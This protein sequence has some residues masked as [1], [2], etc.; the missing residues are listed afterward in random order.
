MNILSKIQSPA[1]L[2]KLERAD[3]QNL[4]TDI[5]KYLVEIIPS[6]GGHFA[7]SL[8][9]VELSVALHFCFD[10]PKDLLIW[11]V[12]HQSYVHKILTGRKEALKKIRQF[13]GISGFTKRSESA[14]D[15]FGAGHASTSISAALGLCTARD[16][17]AETH[18]V[19]AIIGDGSLTGGLA[20]EGLNN[21]GQ[22]GK[23]LLVILNDNNMSISPN[24]GAIAYYLNEIITNPLYQRINNEVWDLTGK[25]PPI[26]E[27]LRTIARKTESSLKAMILPGMLFE[28]LGF[29]YF[30]PVNGHDLNELISYL[31]RLKDL[32]GPVLL[33]VLTKKG[34][35]FS[36]AEKHPEKYH[37]I[38]PST[39]PNVTAQE[40]P[41]QLSYTDIFGKVLVQLAELDP[42]IC[43]ITAA[44]CDG[45]GLNDFK[46]R[47]PER[48][49]DVGIAEEH[50]VTYAAG[51]AAGGFRPVVSIYS[52]FLQRAF[53][54][55]IHDVALQ[56]LPVVLAID[57]GG[58]VGED[59]PTHHGSFDLSYL[60]LIPDLIIASPKDGQELRNLLY[61]ATRQNESPFV[62]RYPRDLAPD[63][64]NLNADFQK[65]KI[66]SWD[67]LHSGENILL[68]AV[69]SMVQ[70]CI[71]TLPLL[72]KHKINPTLVNCRFIKPIDETLLHDLL[73]KHRV[74]LTLE[75]NSLQGGFGQKI[76]NIVISGEYARKI[77][78]QQ[79][80]LPDQ[81]IT[82]GERGILLDRI[83]LSAGQIAKW[84]VSA[85]KGKKENSKSLPEHSLIGSLITSL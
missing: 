76:G 44:M 11:D 53:D 13:G 7:S 83:G 15:A 29:R 56:K 66:G 65:I 80:G 50:A 5:R 58:L 18:R 28:D 37:G 62:I 21:A 30:G 16:L 77:S 57:R 46:Q 72:K 78:F 31:N 14:Y 45:T 38:K 73:E 68:L 23:N 39:P 20:Y 84:I 67:I 22:S 55:I 25:I 36:D 1:D 63:E 32:P 52:T 12:G 59:G 3:L 9:V 79:K 61:T 60:N 19:V 49:F 51:L 26:T 64:I 6:I 48:F 71:K 35:G 10:T 69:G 70:E 75:E 85:V 54:Q 40:R 82:H 43:A 17:K 74:V 34:K 27:K 42:K 81:F 8:G 4:C 24:V 41:K 33:H 2:K 47:F